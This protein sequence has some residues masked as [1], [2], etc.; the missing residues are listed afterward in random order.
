MLG[1]HIFEDSGKTSKLHNAHAG[2]L[3]STLQI[4]ED[5]FKQALK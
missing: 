2:T 4:P 1:M 5:V 3:Q